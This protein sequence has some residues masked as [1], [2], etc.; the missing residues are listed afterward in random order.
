[1]AINKR[2]LYLGGEVVD[3][4]NS[5]GDVWEG[6]SGVSVDLKSRME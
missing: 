5:F 6:R 1:M 2:S 3:L 4:K